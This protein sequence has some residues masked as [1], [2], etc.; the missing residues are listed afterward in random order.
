MAQRHTR[1]TFAGE[2][3]ESGE[4]DSWSPAR[5]YRVRGLGELHGPLAKLTEK[6]AQPGSG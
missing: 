1:S 4:G 6:L 5:L 3:K 2:R